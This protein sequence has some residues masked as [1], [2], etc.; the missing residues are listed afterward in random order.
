[1]QI[2]SRYEVIFLRI[3]KFNDIRSPGQKSKK[4]KIRFAACSLIAGILLGIFSKW[5]D[6]L[7]LDSSIWWHRII[8]RLDLGNF[9]SEMA[10]WLLIALS[11][12]VFS[13]S[14]LMAALNV[15]AFFAGMCAPYHLYSILVAGFNP[16]SYMVI[17]YV[18]ALI[19]P[20]LAV[21]CWYAKGK[22]RIPI[23]LDT[24]IMAIFTLAS[25]SIGFIYIDF[26]GI[27]YLLVYIGAA[28]ILYRNPKQTAI[29]LPVGFLVAFLLNPFWPFK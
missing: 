25:F 3:E 18:I 10:V 14:A 9:F 20:A 17:W 28:V 29:S 22:G 19:S 15:F 7:A 23:L 24:G 13:S 5:L 12:A 1:M 4:D 2:I 27:L 16:S 11:L 21:L 26:R 8:E 6:S